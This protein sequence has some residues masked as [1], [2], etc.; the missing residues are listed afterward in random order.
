MKG[1]QQ[2]NNNNTISNEEMNTAMNKIRD[3]D[4]N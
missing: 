3:M 4:D 1:N 2:Y